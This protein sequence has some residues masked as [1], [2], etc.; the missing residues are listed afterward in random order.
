MSNEIKQQIDNK[1]FLSKKIDKSSFFDGLQES[2]MAIYILNIRKLL[3]FQLNDIIF[4]DLIF[5]VKI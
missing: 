4:M 2:E 5:D 1:T 3:Q